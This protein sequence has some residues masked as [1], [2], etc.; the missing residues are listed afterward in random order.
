MPARIV[1]AYASCA[2]QLYEAHGFAQI[3]IRAV[4]SAPGPLST[5]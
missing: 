5:Q 1:Y 2:G 4:M 3:G